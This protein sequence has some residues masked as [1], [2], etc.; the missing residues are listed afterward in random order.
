MDAYTAYA[1]IVTSAP[2][3]VEQTEVPTNYEGGGGT[4]SNYPTCTIA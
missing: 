1:A 4:G 2:V 3:P